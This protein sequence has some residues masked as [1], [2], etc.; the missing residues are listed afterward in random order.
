MRLEPD[1][2]RRV[3]E[4]R[5]YFPDWT[6]PLVE[7]REEVEADHN[8]YLAGGY[9][10]EFGYRARAGSSRGV[11][12]LDGEPPEE[13]AEWHHQAGAIHP[14]Y[15]IRPRPIAFD[16]E[17]T[18]TATPADAERPHIVAPQEVALEIRGNHGTFVRVTDR[19]Y[20]HA[21]HHVEQRAAAVLTRFV[22][23]LATFRWGLP[24]R[25]R[26]SSGRKGQP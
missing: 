13:S 2:A 12:V 17:R 19:P 25:R 5:R 26:A 7:V 10:E 8:S 22:A 4:D 18:G 24:H 11:W 16:G 6:E 20:E 21:R 1:S 15:P 14:G 9:A 3:D 23:A